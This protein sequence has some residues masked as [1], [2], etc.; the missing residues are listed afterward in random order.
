[1]SD[2]GLAYVLVVV[3]PPSA[4][5]QAF[6]FTLKGTRYPHPIDELNVNR[7]DAAR[8]GL[9][10]PDGFV[11]RPPDPG[12]EGTM[13]WAPELALAL[14]P[15]RPRSFVFRFGP[16]DSAPVT[17]GIHLKTP[18][19]VG[20]GLVLFTVRVALRD[21]LAIEAANLR[22]QLS[23]RARELGVPAN[24]LPEWASLRDLENRLKTGVE[25]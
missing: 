7:T 23:A 10:P 3:R 24:S 15:D 18:V 5:S 25:P 21:P 2:V 4:D 19:R 17:V 8:I 20:G 11:A 14:E 6:E 12:R 1:M 16:A 13:V 9:R 22:S